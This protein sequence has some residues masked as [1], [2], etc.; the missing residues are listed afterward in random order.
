MVARDETK[1]KAQFNT[2]FK[3]AMKVTED[4][5]APDG[6]D[7]IDDHVDHQSFEING[8]LELELWTCEYDLKTLSRQLKPHPKNNGP[9]RDLNVHVNYVAIF[10]RGPHQPSDGENVVITRLHVMGINPMCHNGLCG[11]K[12]VSA[13]RGFN[14]GAEQP[15]EGSNATQQ[16]IVADVNR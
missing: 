8:S 4:D 16:L 11:Q 12:L 14:C 15:H 7:N 1:I 13:S 9:D 5:S 3:T 6:N 2:I 10:L